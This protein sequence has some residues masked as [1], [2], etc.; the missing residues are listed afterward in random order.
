M[1]KTLDITVTLDT[2][3]PEAARFIDD[4]QSRIDDF[5]ESR[6]SSPVPGFVPSDF[7]YV[8]CA[9]ETIQSKHIAPGDAFCE[10]GSGFGVVASLAAMLG[11]EACGIEIDEDLVTEAESL[12]DDHD[13]T[14][15][16]ARGTFIPQHAEHHTDHANEQAWLSLGGADGYDQI[17]MDP[18]DFDLIF[19][20]PW[21][22]E[23]D[24]IYKIFDACAAVGAVLITYH[25]IDD[26]SIRRKVS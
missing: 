16:F 7:S 1:L 10:W 13:I 6:R 2:I 5:F 9:L 19:A 18:N 8:Y 14:V 23:E 3:P 12:A 25:G 17:G 22:G 4:A 15:E 24:T 11:F 20:Y 26:V 21:P